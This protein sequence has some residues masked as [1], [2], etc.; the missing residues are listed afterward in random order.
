MAGYKT[1]S[2]IHRAVF[3]LT[4]GRVGASLQ[5]MPMVVMDC[6]GRKSGKV[7]STPVN[8]YA[9][10]NSV[11]V[12]A[13]NNGSEKP[14]IWWLNLQAN[15][16]ITIQLGRKRVEVTAEELNDEDKALVWPEIIAANPR[17]DAYEK[18]T[19]RKLPVVYFKPRNEN[20]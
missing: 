12:V 5:G 6:I 14:P 17:Q 13:S 20:G 15:P 1:F 16:N 19:S 11:V 7:R 8:C 9:F 2:K 3:K 10:K 18:Q 4:G